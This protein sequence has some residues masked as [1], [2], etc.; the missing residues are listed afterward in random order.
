[1]HC[2]NKS[3]NVSTKKL[4]S[5]WM[6]DYIKDLISEKLRLHLLSASLPQYKE[7]CNSL[8]ELLN[9]T[10]FIANSNY[11]SSKINPSNGD[12]KSTWKTLNHIIRPNRKFLPLSFKQITLC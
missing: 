9:K 4:T 12:S 10:I 7:S 11:H 2:K 5:P 8:A 6:I 3:K 1:M